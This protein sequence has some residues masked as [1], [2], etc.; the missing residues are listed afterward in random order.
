MEG[1]HKDTASLHAFHK[2]IAGE[3]KA[4][5]IDPCFITGKGCVYTDA[6][7]RNR[8]NDARVSAGFLITP[9]QPNVRSFA[10]LALTPYLDRSSASG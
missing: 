9:F 6:I 7:L 5:C 10:S 2:I 4:Q 3:P 8:S 1:K